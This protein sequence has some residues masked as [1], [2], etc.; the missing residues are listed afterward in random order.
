VVL[1]ASAPAAGVISAAVVPGAIGSEQTMS[2]LKRYWQHWRT[3]A[4]DARRLFPEDGLTAIGHAVRQ[5]E[6]GSSG[7]ICVCIE[8]ALPWSY[9]RKDLSTRHRAIT[10]FGKLRVWDTE[11]NNGTL[12]YVNVAEHKLEIIVDRA[13]A[14]RVDAQEWPRIARLAC[15]ELHAGR[16]VQGVEWAVMECGRLLKAHFPSERD[17]SGNELPDQPVMLG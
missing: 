3:E 11:D 6:S 5:A 9:L 8:P 2:T 14:R 17:D 4:R 1:V 15:D 10:L 13:L 16:H 7:E 12:I